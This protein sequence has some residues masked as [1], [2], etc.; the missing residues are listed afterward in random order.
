MFNTS[1]KREYNPRYLEVHLDSRLN[2]KYH[3]STICKTAKR[4]MNMLTSLCGKNWGT[5]CQ[6]ILR[7]YC[8]FV[9]PTLKY[10]SEVWHDQS[11]FISQIKLIHWRAMRLVLSALRSTLIS[12]L[13][14]DLN[15]YN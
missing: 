14:T 7:L 2:W 11:K 3:I 6:S 13:E 10:A 12:V 4:K 9:R 5:N 1:I 8:G 15:C